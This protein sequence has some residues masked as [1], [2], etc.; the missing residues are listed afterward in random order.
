LILAFTG[1]VIHKPEMF[2]I[3]HFKGVVLVHNIMAALLVA[4]AALALAYNLL[5]GDIKRF[6]PEPRGFFNQSIIQTRYYLS[7]I[8][9]NEP[10]P[11]EKTR[12]QRLNP[13][14][15]VTYFMVLNVLLPL[16]TITGILMWG[17]QRWPQI[18]NRFGGL[19]LL[20]PFHTLI[21]WS[22]VAFIILHVYLTTTGHTPMAGIKSM[23]VG[24][25]EVEVH[26]PEPESTEEE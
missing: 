19:P 12:E 20:A 25:D 4:N 5:S 23:I 7:G 14:Q 3:F 17:V 26:S 1:L 6:I 16:Q 8:F 9:K 24:W 10:H 21:S 15:Q 2:G 18:S 11:F 13:L 22:F